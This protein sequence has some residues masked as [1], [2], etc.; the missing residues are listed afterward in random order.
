MKYELRISF[1]SLV[2]EPLW[3]GK[4]FILYIYTKRTASL[5]HDGYQC[6]WYNIMGRSQW[7]YKNLTAKAA[8]EYYTTYIPRYW[9]GWVKITYPVLFAGCRVKSFPGGL[10]VGGAALEV[11]G[12]HR[13]VN[14]NRHRRRRWLALQTSVVQRSDAVSCWIFGGSDVDLQAAHRSA[15]RVTAT[16]LFCGNRAPHVYNQNARC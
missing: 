2:N 7:M 4:I 10:Y 12:P 1:G 15:F 9:F 5:R 8:H 13:G 6:I 3:Y 16:K 14:L 11:F